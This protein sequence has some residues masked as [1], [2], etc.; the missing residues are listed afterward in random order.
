MQRR[1]RR[2]VAACVLVALVLATILMIGGLR[3][4]APAKVIVEEPQAYIAAPPLSDDVAN[5]LLDEPAEEPTEIP[6]EAPVETLFDEAFFVE[7]PV[8]EPTVTP[9]EMS[10]EVYT[11]APAEMALVPTPLQENTPNN[12]AWKLKY[13]VYTDGDPVKNYNRDGETAF[14]EDG[15]YSAIE[16]VTTFR[17]GNLRQ[18]AAYGT[19]ALK[20]K[21]FKA[22]W[23]NSIGAIDSGYAEWTGVGWTGQPAMVRWPASLRTVMNL[24]PEYKGKENLIEVIYATLD[25]NIYFLDGDTGEYTREPI[26][27]GFPIKGSVSVDPRGYPLLYVGQGISK[28]DGV[29]GKIGWRVYSLLD[30]RELFFL[31][32][33]DKLAYRNHHGAFDGASLVDAATDTVLQGG[34]NGI[35]YS[36]KLN[37][38]FDISVPYVSVSPEVTAYRYK[39]AISS[40]L[41]IENSVAALGRYAWFADNSGLLTCMDLNHMEPVWLMDVGDDTDSTIALE[42][43]ADGRLALYTV[44]QVDKQGATGICTLCKVDAMTGLPEWFFTVQCESDGTNG[45]GGFASPAVGAGAYANYIYFNICRTDEGGMVYCFNKADGRVVWS[46]ATGNASWSSPVLV[47]RPDGTGVLIV[48]NVNGRGVLRM[49]DPATGKKLDKIELEGKIEGSPAV[50]GDLLVVG[51]R[52]RR[53][54]GVRLR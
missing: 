17:G 7:T 51:T 30:Q 9:T 39:S 52:D 35:F 54:Y 26:H 10:A 22:L 34:E 11:P 46:Q 31:D 29:T 3:R 50:F 18:N 45:G 15:S 21:R 48:A 47:Y 13:G 40:E 28:A 6:E 33:E 19:A 24:K 53:I 4:R 49:Y 5:L 14:P 42:R 8:E 36:V 44:N 20:E 2:F 38:A 25:G 43:E 23:K 32:G 12:S 1:R 16:G 37:T 27:L 41:G